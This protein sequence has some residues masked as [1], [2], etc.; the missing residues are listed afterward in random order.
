MRQFA[1]RV[2]IHPLFFLLPACLS[3]IASVFEGV[4]V[5]LLIPFVKGV[6]EMNFSF[7]REI[8]F[9]QVVVQYLP[10]PWK[11][12]NAPLFG[13]LLLIIVGASVI[14][15][16]FTYL[17]ALALS[18]QV[19]KVMHELRSLVFQRYLSFGKLYFDKTSLGGITQILMSSIN[20]LSNALMNL[21]QCVNALFMLVVYVGM[22][23]CIS[24]QLTVLVF[25]AFPIFS[26]SMN[27]LVNKIKKTSG[28]ETASR[29]ELSRRLTNILSCI[30]LVKAY[31]R[32]KEELEIFQS[33]SRDLHRSEF[34]LSKKMNLVYPIQEIMLHVMFLMLVCFITFL[35]VKIQTGIIAGYLVFFYI[36]KRSLNAMTVI[37][38]IKSHAAYVSGPIRE[39]LDVLSDENKYQIAGGPETFTGLIQ[40]IEFRNLSFYYDEKRPVLK[41][42]NLTIPK[43][44]ITA[45]VGPSGAGKTTLIN[46]LMRFY[47]CGQGM[48]MLDGTEIHDYSL[49]SLRMH[50]AVVGQE[51]LLFNES[52]RDNV[53]FGLEGT[54]TEPDLREAVRRARLSDFVRELPQ[55]LETLIGDRG[56]QLSGG[57]K[58]RV[59]IARAMLKKAEILILDEATSA[60]DS[61]TE[62]EIQEA[63]DAVVKGHTA[64]VIAHRLST[65]RHADKI[66]VL[67][68]GTI[69][70][71]GSLDEL[72]K[73]KGKFFE[74]WEAQK[75]F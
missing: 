21:N 53:T 61:K 49:S 73:N 15:N 23:S 11:L 52:L 42:L 69:L 70:E 55:G 68:Q 26:F 22:M 20:R 65:I 41:G 7:V 51:T 10:E 74:L 28:L 18:Y 71:E 19:T 54:V 32:E 45:L 25:L 30:P 36:I 12:R 57:E 50:M 8:P 59:S 34:S 75:F 38:G 43:G 46:I 1:R 62:K 47:D 33:L 56:V 16:I 3:L 17:S 64:I 40:A 60:L 58:Q 72:L 39:I 13:S 63:I 31:S 14:K 44:K 48:L 37:N 67:D 4:S 35:I 2:K 6:I 24:W 5:G 66:A 27:W 29:T 9:F